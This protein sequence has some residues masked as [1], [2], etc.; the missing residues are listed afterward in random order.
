MTCNGPLGPLCKSPNIHEISQ[1]E[2]L[3]PWGLP[4]WAFGVAFVDAPKIRL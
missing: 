3:Q 1:G 2:N 4:L